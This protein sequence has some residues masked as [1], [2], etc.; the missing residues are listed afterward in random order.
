MK[1]KLLG[2][3]NGVNVFGLSIEN[4]SRH[5]RFDEFQLH[6]CSP[7]L[8]SPDYV[9]FLYRS[10]SYDRWNYI[11]ENGVDVFPI[12]SVI[13]CDCLEKASEYGEWPKIIMGFSREKMNRTFRE[14]NSDI[15]CSELDQLL[16]VYSTQEKSIDG[17]KLW[18]SRLA[19]DDPRRASSYE[20]AYAWWIPG[21]PWD[22]LKVL[23]LA[24]LSDREWVL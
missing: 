24:D 14:V 10:V 2:S 9:G 18:L 21:N 3:V 20:I 5:T 15:D 13:Y 12:D 8:F 7:H 1:L 16:E 19:E 4:G 22:S 11:K 17:S 6:E 23:I